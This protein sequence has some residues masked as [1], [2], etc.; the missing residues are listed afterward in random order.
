MIKNFIA[1]GASITEYIDHPDGITKTWA[2]Y[3]AEDLGVENHINLASSGVGND[4]ICHSTIKD[5]K[6]TRLNSSH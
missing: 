4:Y 2:T 6:S 1:N 3:L 5:R